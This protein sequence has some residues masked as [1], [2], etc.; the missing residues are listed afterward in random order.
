MLL[1]V[2]HGRQ[3]V[4]YKVY[5]I[6]EQDVAVFSVSLLGK[7]FNIFSRIRYFWTVISGSVVAKGHNSGE[8]SGSRFGFQ[9]C[10]MKVCNCCPDALLMIFTLRVKVKG[11]K[12]RAWSGKG[13]G[14]QSCEPLI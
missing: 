2:A 4:E 12:G 8:V 11:C 6:V 7:K 3:Q 14:S 1:T 10:F 9:C 5:C 13:T